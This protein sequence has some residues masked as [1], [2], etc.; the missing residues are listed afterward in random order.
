MTKEDQFGQWHPVVADGKRRAA[1]RPSYF[2]T[3]T[4][5]F[6]REQIALLRAA[7]D[8]QNV[9]AQVEGYGLSAD[10]AH[11]PSQR[12]TRIRWLTQLI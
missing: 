1:G 6:S 3:G 9:P 7:I 5:V 10:N 12:R 11:M 8:Q 2:L 4:P